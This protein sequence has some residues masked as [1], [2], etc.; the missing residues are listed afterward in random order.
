VECVRKKRAVLT[1]ATFLIVVLL[2][3]GSLALATGTTAQASSATYAEPVPVDDIKNAAR[4]AYDYLLALKRSEGLY[5]VIAEYPSVPITVHASNGW[6]WIPGLRYYIA[7]D[8]SGETYLHVVIR[9]SSIETGTYGTSYIWYMDLRIFTY[10]AASGISYD[11][12]DATLKVTE[13]RGYPYSYVTITVVDSA[14]D[15]LNAEI[16]L[17]GN[18]VGQLK[19]GNSFTVQVTDS[20]MPSMRT[21]VRHV[22]NIGLLA[23]MNI[24]NYQE[25]DDL[26]NFVTEV[27]YHIFG[28]SR[29]PYDIYNTIFQGFEYTGRI[30]EPN[31]WHF[32]D[33]QWFDY[34]LGYYRIW[35][36]MDNKSWIWR[37]YPI[38]PYK[39]KIVAFA[40][41]SHI[42]GG[43]AF[44]GMSDVLSD[45]LYHAWWGLYY[46]YTGDYSSAVQEWNEIVSHWDGTGI[47][48]R[49]QNGYSTVRLAVAVIL[50]SI[51][52]DKGY[53]SWDTVHEMANVL[54]QLQWQ[55][56][57][58]YSEDGSN[59]IYIYKPDH[60]GGF[61]VSYGKIGSYGFVPFR[62]PTWESIVDW[63]LQ[64]A[65]MEKEYGGVVPTNAETTVLALVALAQYA[66]HYYGIPPSQLLS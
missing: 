30:E 15:D 26:W 44:L 33:A 23:L 18:Y 29:P 38:Y 61:M 46:A 21:S 42:N 19:K 20:P 22:D 5:A 41:E 10:D 36:F 27:L 45:P 56:S 39:S 8:P 63:F 25:Q 3:A 28:D 11:I 1:Y 48:V 35:Q 66:Y 13:Y 16:Y 7:K 43:K 52:A 47:Y 9:D 12:T 6:W 60:R 2:L 40:E 37:P 24:G 34:G 31:E 64:S 59:V 53:I 32:Y 50:G 4:G 65:E 49:G 51:L 17:A 58:H 14:I 54:V 57:G 55:G 62:S